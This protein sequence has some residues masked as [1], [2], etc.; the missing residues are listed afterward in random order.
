MENCIEYYD[1]SPYIWDYDEP[2]RTVLLW[3]DDDWLATDKSVATRL[4]LHVYKVK[5]N[6]LIN[7]C[8]IVLKDPTLDCSASSSL[9]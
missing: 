3:C 1:G 2:V 7:T 5:N 4:L 8:Y 9:P 6:E